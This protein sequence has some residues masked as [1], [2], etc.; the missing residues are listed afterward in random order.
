[1]ELVWSKSLGHCE[2]NVD[3]VSAVYVEGIDVLTCCVRSFH[4]LETLARVGSYIVP[5]M[6]RHINTQGLSKAEKPK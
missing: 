3:A 1:M 2:L 4:A 5:A 6:R